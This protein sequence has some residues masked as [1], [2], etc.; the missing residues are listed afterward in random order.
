M[1]QSSSLKLS[2]LI[3]IISVIAI[4]VFQ[5]GCNY[6][7][8]PGENWSK[9]VEVE[10]NAFSD[11]YLVSD[12]EAEWVLF[13]YYS[14][15]SAQPVLVEKIGPYHWITVFEKPK[16]NPL[17]CLRVEKVSESEYRLLLE[18]PQNNT[19]GN[20]TDRVFENTA[21]KGTKKFDQMSTTWK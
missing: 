12:R 9:T 20:G 5:L 1:Y 19:K 2:I 4:C 3:G 11:A 10:K 7:T 18:C 8:L 14:A 13:T 6:E 16:K 15:P 17:E 21:W